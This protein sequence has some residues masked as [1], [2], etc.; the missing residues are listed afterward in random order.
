MKILIGVT[1]SVAA[2]KLPDLVRS[3]KARDPSVEIRVV[4]TAHAKWFVKADDL[5]VSEVYSDE[6]EWAAWKQKGDPVLHIELRKWADIFLIAPLS[7][8]SLAKMANG[9]CDNLLT[10]IVRAWDTQKR[11]IVCPA[12]NTYMWT[13]PFTEKH[14][15]VVRDIY[16]ANVVRPKENYALACGDIGPGAMADVAD[17]VDIVL[18]AA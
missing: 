14:L 16:S 5:D 18:S 10:S 12:M 17:I 8:N 9:M 11:L 3:F 15:N 7:A 2:I 4:T 1:G 13:N 6:T